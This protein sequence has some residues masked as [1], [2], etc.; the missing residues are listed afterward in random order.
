VYS[1]A[2]G[3]DIQAPEDSF[4][5][6]KT[7]MD[8]LRERLLAD[9]TRWSDEVSFDEFISGFLHWNEQT[10][11]SPSGRHLGVYRALVT[12]YC[13]SSGE[14]ADLTPG[15]ETSTQ[16]MAEQILVMIHGLAATAARQGFYLHHWVKVVNVMIYKKPD[17]V[18]LDKLRV[19]LLLLQLNVNACSLFQN[20]M[21]IETSYGMYM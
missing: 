21:R 10:T 18:E 16:E 8:I 17:C 20:F 3:K 9:P 14:S 5:E 13:N 15:L 12:A 1:D 2:Q 4:V 11:T 6:T 7:V 19:I